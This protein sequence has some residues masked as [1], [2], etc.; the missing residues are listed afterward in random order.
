M[1]GDAAGT[2]KVYTNRNLQPVASILLKPCNDWTDYSGKLELPAAT[3]PLYFIFEGSGRLD[4][5][6]FE[7]Q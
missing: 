7:I 6:A 5:A 3:V 1:R 4:F 2:L